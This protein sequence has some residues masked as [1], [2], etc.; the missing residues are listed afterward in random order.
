MVYASPD[1]PTQVS[2]VAGD[3]SA[4]VYFD[5]GSNK[6]RYKGSS[7]VVQSSTDAVTASGTG[8]P[9]KITGLQNNVGYSF[10]V[11]ACG[12]SVDA[13][14]CSDSPAA[15]RVFPIAS[16]SAALKSGWNLMGNGSQTSWN[17]GT[18]FGDA[19]QFISVW[20]WVA[21]SSKWAFYS[22]ALSASSLL[23]YTRV[24]GYDVLA[25]VGPGEGIWVNA[26]VPLSVALPVDA[27]VASSRFMTSKTGWGLIAVGD[28][29]S[30]RAFNFALSET[31]PATDVIPE[32]LISLWAWDTSQAKWYFYS[33]R[34]DA[35]HGLLDYISLKGYLDFGTQLLSTN[36]GFWINKAAVPTE[37]EPVRKLDGFW[38]GTFYDQPKNMTYTLC[39]RQG[40]AHLLANGWMTLFLHP[41]TTCP[42]N[43]LSGLM[44]IPFRVDNNS[45]IF[46]LDGGSVVNLDANEMPI[47]VT[48]VPRGRGTVS[49]PTADSPVLNI[50]LDDGSLLS[51]QSDVS[52]TSAKRPIVADFSKTQ[53]RYLARAGSDVQGSD[54]SVSADGTISGTLVFPPADNMSTELLTCSI[55]LGDKALK[56]GY[57]GY[58]VVSPL[59]LSCTKR[60]DGTQIKKR[61]SGYAL[62]IRSNNG[63]Y[64]DKASVVGPSNAATLFLMLFD[65]TMFKPTMVFGSDNLVLQ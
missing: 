52:T 13:V 45:K 19:A 41:G 44:R 47:G 39:N 14:S 51:L 34:L 55:D 28:T 27:A 42:A 36:T 21:E 57:G 23:D 63:S 30:P 58:Y 1:T 22:P 48:A 16:Q 62:P 17:V 2:V 65:Q 6:C 3:Q 40:D 12:G 54:F 64:G 15:D 18:M 20:K 43:Q 25:S 35:A 56:P 53:G 59:E 7:F 31:P 61:T 29:P 11:R 10:T 24:K 49:M 37:S 9:I 4:T 26:R 38:Y 50:Q 33:P 32:N 60:S 46:V 8:S 5:T